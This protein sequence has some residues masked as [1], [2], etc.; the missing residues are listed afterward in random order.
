MRWLR[1][2]AQQGGARGIVASDQVVEVE[3]AP[4][5]GY[6]PTGISHPRASIEYLPPA[7]LREVARRKS[8]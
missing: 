1:F 3:G 2:F 4:F 6:T 5:T 8:G 7:R